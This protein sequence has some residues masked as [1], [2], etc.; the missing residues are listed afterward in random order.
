MRPAARLRSKR[1]RHG[2]RA[3]R[4]R[5]RARRARERATLAARASDD[6]RTGP[7]IRASHASAG[8]ARARPAGARVEARRC[9]RDRV[10]V[11]LA[12]RAAL[13]QRQRV[14]PLGQPPHHHQCS[15]SRGTRAPARAPRARAGSPTRRAH[16]RD[17]E[18]H[19]LRESAIQ[20]QLAQRVG[21]PRARVEKSTKP[22]RTALCSLYTRLRSG[23]RARGASG[24]A[25]R[26]APRSG[27]RGRPMRARGSRP[28]PAR[29]ARRAAVRRS[30]RIACLKTRPGVMLRCVRS[31]GE[32]RR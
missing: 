8:T 3:A 13:E 30:R 2:G 17:A 31:A 25:A 16:R 20:V 28:A 14:A 15:A 22:K 32:G 26:R 12:Q 9:A 4:A 27:R 7:A 10:D 23:T 6:S 29:A 1:C 24:C 19:V 21:V 11:A 18:I 5:A